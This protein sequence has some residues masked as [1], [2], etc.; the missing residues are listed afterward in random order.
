MR[1]SFY[2]TSYTKKYIILLFKFL[3]NCYYCCCYKTYGWIQKKISCG[4]RAFEL[5]KENN[6]QRKTNEKE[7]RRKTFVMF[8]EQQIKHIRVKFI[9]GK[10]EENR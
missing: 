1:E 7:K 6:T 10:I 8:K 2:F 3:F 9:H 4:G 5:K